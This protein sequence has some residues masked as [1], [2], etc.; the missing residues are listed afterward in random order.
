MARQCIGSKG[1]CC[2]YRHFYFFKLFKLVGLL[3][4]I[5]ATTASGFSRFFN[6]QIT[7]CLNDVSC[8]V[9]GV[10]EVSPY[11]VNTNH[12]A[13]TS[14]YNCTSGDCAN[15]TGLGIE[16]WDT[17]IALTNKQNLSTDTLRYV[18]KPTD[19][20]KSL[21]QNLQSG[22]IDVALMMPKSDIEYSAS[23]SV[24]SYSSAGLQFVFL[25]PSLTDTFAELSDM[26]APLL[27][28]VA[29]FFAIAMF[30][31]N[32]LWFFE[33]QHR[34]SSFSK[35]YIRGIGQASYYSATTL[36]SVGFGDKTAK[37][38]SGRLFTVLMAATGILFTSW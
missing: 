8:I 29:I 19:D 30:A 10:R 37:T 18:V 3:A 24:S 14:S 21:V 20:E 27:P 34:R 28:Y 38:V 35:E 32:L 12:L 4:T 22:K 17:L 26:L 36:T 7:E 2:E 23:V 15:L 16:L 11:A 13:L 1:R 25:E 9:A 31:A 33:R 6:D 5:T